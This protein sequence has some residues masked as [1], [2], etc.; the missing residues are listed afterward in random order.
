M[1]F[2][3]MAPIEPGIVLSLEDATKRLSVS[4][5]ITTGHDQLTNLRTFPAK[6][7]CNGAHNTSIAVYNSRF[8]FPSLFYYRFSSH[9]L[10]M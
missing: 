6:G 3:R 5:Y 7:F 8:V 2:F 10:Q 4:R 1:I 9:F